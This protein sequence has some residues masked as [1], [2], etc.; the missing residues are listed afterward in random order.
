MTRQLATL[1]AR[2][3]GVMVARS[4]ALAD[5]ATPTSPTSRNFSTS[6]PLNLP[7]FRT[8]LIRSGGSRQ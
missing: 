3:Q 7:R 1:V 2:F 6:P 8:W 4:Y 5:Y